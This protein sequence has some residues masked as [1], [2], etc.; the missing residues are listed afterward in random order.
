MLLTV[1][2]SGD[3]YS[4]DSLIF[5]RSFKGKKIP[6][7]AVLIFQL[8]ITIVFF[9]ATTTKI[10]SDWLRGQFEWEIERVHFK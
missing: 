3:C 4:L 8:Q 10:Q 1:A 5:Q 7:W 6:R 9:F 2:P